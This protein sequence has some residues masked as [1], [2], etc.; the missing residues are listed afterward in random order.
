[1]VERVRRAQHCSRCL[2]FAPGVGGLPFAV[3]VDAQ[4]RIVKTLLGETP[5]GKFEEL[6]R[7]LVS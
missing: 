1:M 4:G 6:V 7:P 5:P 2:A 3:V